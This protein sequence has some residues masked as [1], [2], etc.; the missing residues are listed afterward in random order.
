[1]SDNGR[2]VINLEKIAGTRDEFLIDENGNTR[3]YI[4]IPVDNEKGLLTTGPQIDWDRTCMT[5]EHWTLNLDYVEL[6]RKIY[7]S[8]VILPGMYPGVEVQMTE[9]QLKSRPVIGNIKPRKHE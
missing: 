8:H 2:I 7:G 1:M 4:C 3:E 6:R 9:Q 5:E